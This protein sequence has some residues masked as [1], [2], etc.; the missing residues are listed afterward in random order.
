M[1]LRKKGARP[2]TVDGHSY[3]WRV[4]GAVRCCPG[5]AWYGRFGFAVQD[6]DRHGPVL[7]SDTSTFPVVPRV[8]A[9]SIQDALQAGWQ[10][11]RPGPAF[12]LNRT[13]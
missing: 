3:R 9:A 7:V 5:C 2:I 10:P 13:V 8:V 11:T 12:H 6:A 4:V 1:A